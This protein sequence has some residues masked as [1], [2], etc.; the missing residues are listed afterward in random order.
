MKREV[1]ENLNHSPHMAPSDFTFLDR[2]EKL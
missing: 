2:L 1:M